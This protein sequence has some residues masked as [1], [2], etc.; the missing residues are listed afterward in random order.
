MWPVRIPH[1]EMTAVQL[2]CWTRQFARDIGQVCLFAR[3]NIFDLAVL[4]G[5][6]F[7]L[8]LPT[9]FPL[10]LLISVRP[11]PNASQTGVAGLVNT[12][13]D[14]ALFQSCCPWS[15]NCSY[16]NVYMASRFCSTPICFTHNESVARTWP[17]CVFGVLSNYLK[18]VHAA[19]NQTNVTMTAM[20][21]MCQYIDYERLKRGLKTGNSSGLVNVRSGWL[22]LGIMVVAYVF[23]M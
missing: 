10:S 22:L 23:L 15:H 3:I 17:T 2:I 20:D 12:W 13:T 18:D 19:G 8:L 14:R 6:S 4:Q 1:L 9:G 16:R 7:S 5:M 21:P 11:Y